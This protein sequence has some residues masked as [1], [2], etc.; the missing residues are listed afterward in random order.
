MT[1]TW[2]SLLEEAVKSVTARPS[3]TILTALGA[4]LGVGTLIAVSGISSTAGA[5]IL[6]RLDGLSVNQVTATAADGISSSKEAMDWEAEE[7]LTVLNGVKAAG[8]RTE[9]GTN[10]DISA[11]EI[12]DPVA[13]TE[14]PPTLVAGS[15]GLAAAVDAV[16]GQGRWFD[17]GHS[18]RADRVA[19]LGSS[20]AGALNI[21]DISI[22]SVVFIEGTPYSVVG[23]VSSAPAQPDLLESVIIPGK[24]AAA[25]FGAKHPSRIQ[26]ATD[27]GASEVVAEQTP[28]ALSPNDPALIQAEYT[29]PPQGVRQAVDSDTQ[30][31]FLVL[32]G[33]SLLAGAVGI[34]NTTLVSVLERRG[35]I[36]LRRAV[37]AARRHIAVQFLM[38]SGMVGL[39]GGLFGMAGGVL[40]IVTVSALNEWTPVAPWWLPLSGVVLGIGTGLLAG[41]MPAWRAARTEPA[42]ALR[43]A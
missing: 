39:L 37:G 21:A 20:T 43:D 41:I 25:N 15:P 4:V 5:Q 23:I 40:T 14:A 18:E 17:V 8:A 10:F 19:V 2:V 38:E 1:L 31:L 28:L 27:S 13:A 11:I 24:T 22:Q 30:L 29:P 33:V 42:V 16:M 6:S 7:N 26:I 12:T 3:R 36:G 34:M 35:E 9:I 32:G